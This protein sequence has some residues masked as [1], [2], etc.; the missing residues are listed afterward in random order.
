MRCCTQRLCLLPPACWA[1]P[2]SAPSCL[3]SP[4]QHVPSCPWPLPWPS[5]QGSRI[6]LFPDTVSKRAQ[7]HVQ[8]LTAV[9]AAGGSAALLFCVQRGD[10]SA[11]APCV[12]KDPEYAA[13]VQQAVAA[14]VRVV[15]VE[16][17]LDAAG[18]VVRY[19][20]L[21]PCELGYKQPAAAEAT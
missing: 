21:L 11:F 2:G 8:E 4:R 15:A 7:R 1:A 18:M 10:C 3:P 19:G 14:G 17:A 13:L 20:G 12:E 6:A 16:A 9:A 5:R